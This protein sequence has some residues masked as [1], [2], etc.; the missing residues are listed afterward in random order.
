MPIRRVS[1]LLLTS[2][3]TL[4]LLPTPVWACACCSDE[5]EYRLSF[6]K[7]NTYELGLLQ[8]IR[9]GPT[10]HLI[11]TQADVAEE[12]KTPGNQSNSFSVTGS[13]QS[14]LWKLL[15]RAGKTTGTL[16][17][18]VPSKMLSYVADI[19]DGQTASGGGPLLYKEWR[20][21]GP[22]TGTGLFKSG[23]ARATKYF[24]VLQG[25]GNRCDNAADF[26]HWRL[27]LN[28]RKA[29]YAFYGELARPSVAAQ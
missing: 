6:R 24:L 8:E 13:L 29:R 4:L 26:T 14:N 9:L 18:P 5:G 27:E 7:P 10:A 1:L 19:H 17:L 22:V 2:F 28:G 23:I 25:R 11:E 16:N 21:E 15:F 3:L 12:I 20:F